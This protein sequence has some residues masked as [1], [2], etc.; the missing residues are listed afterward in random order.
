MRKFLITIDFQTSSELAS[1]RMV[2]DSFND[3]LINKSDPSTESFEI[4]KVEE[5]EGE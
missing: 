1:K 5:V 2:F 3:L 4:I